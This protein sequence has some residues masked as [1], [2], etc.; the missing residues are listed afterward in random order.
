MG[1]VSG[2]LYFVV[3]YCISV[4]HLGVARIRRPEGQEI[5]AIEEEDAEDPY[6]YLDSKY[7]MACDRTKVS[8][9]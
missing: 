2:F 7:D 9:F 3:F 8:M 6:G 5:P 1:S 4:R